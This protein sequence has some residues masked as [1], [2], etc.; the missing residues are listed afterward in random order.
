MVLLLQQPPLQLLLLQ[1]QADQLRAIQRQP[2]A[3]P[4]QLLQLR[5]QLRARQQALQGDLLVGDLRKAAAAQN[6]C[7][8]LPV[9]TA[10]ASP[11]CVEVA[12]AQ[13]AAAQLL[14]CGAC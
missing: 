12:H 5:V 9:V 8:W 1:R 10:P 4:Q 13:P 6:G 7:R 3:L 2:P 11:R 14:H